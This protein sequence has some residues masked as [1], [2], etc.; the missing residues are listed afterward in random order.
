[1]S[2]F[3][4]IV[5]F[6]T[7]VFIGLCLFYSSFQG[8]FIFDDY[9]YVKNNFLIKTLSLHNLKEIFSS[10]YKWH[11]LPV[12]LISF[13]I[14]YKF[15]GLNPAGYHLTNLI[16]HIFNCFLI[17]ILVFHIS[18]SFLITCLTSLFFLIH[19]ISFI[20]LT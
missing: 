7:Y 10:F 5:F 14:D 15:F 8:Q 1:M 12:T 11:F 16:L 2:L 6:S 19:P 3:E 4:H 9:H 18:K 17:H 13:A 20:Y